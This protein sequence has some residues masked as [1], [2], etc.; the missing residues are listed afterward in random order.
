MAI[1]KKHKERIEKFVRIVLNQ[2]VTEEIARVFN[3]TG[4]L[5]ENYTITLYNGILLPMYNDDRIEVNGHVNG[6]KIP[7]FFISGES[8][9]TQK[10]DD[11]VVK[12]VVESFIKLR[13][14]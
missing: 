7:S 5:D 14:K 8:M 12:K 10:L 11:V 1:P 2:V 9:V 4:K 3:K 6:K 13:V